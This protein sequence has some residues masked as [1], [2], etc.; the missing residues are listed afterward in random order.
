VPAGG[1]IPCWKQRTK[2]QGLAWIAT[3]LRWVLDA[4]DLTSFLTH[5]SARHRRGLAFRV[6]LWRQFIPDLV[7]AETADYSI[8]SFSNTRLH[9]RR[10]WGI[11]ADGR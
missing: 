4:F 5:R 10:P 8:L 2:G 11:C 1:S 7:P 6:R 9:T 3:R